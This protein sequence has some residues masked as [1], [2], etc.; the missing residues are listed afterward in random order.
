[1]K[2]PYKATQ[3]AK[4]KRTDKGKRWQGRGAINPLTPLPAAMGNGTAPWRPA[5]SY[6]LKFTYLPID[7]EVSL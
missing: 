1:M 5:V 4:T 7:P 6:K 2:C 3:V